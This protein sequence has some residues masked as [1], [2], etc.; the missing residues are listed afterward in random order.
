M[1]LPMSQG[2][3]YVLTSAAEEADQLSHQL[4][5]TDHLLQGLPRDPE[6][7]AAQTLGRSG[8]SLDAVRQHLKAKSKEP[9]P[10]EKEGLG[11]KLLQS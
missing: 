10:I 4:I 3:K 7:F 9:S 5:G 2:R 1:D 6:S 11:P 8:L